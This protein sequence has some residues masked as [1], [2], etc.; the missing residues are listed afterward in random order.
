MHIGLAQ[1]NG[2][3]RTGGRFATGRLSAVVSHGG[4]SNRMRQRLSD[5]RY[6]DAS[7]NQSRSSNK[8]AMPSERL[9]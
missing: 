7:A 9:D 1:A 4:R 2:A 6:S 8:D 3:M 5:I